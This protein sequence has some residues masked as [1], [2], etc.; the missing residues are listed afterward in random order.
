MKIT[1]PMMVFFLILSLPSYTYMSN[2]KEEVQEEQTFAQEDGLGAYIATKPYGM[3][4][5]YPVQQFY[6]APGWQYNSTPEKGNQVN[7]WV[8][9]SWGNGSYYRNEDGEYF[10]WDPVRRNWAKTR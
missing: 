9:P 7:T 10:F 2:K 4:N 6:K 3:D 5:Y 1:L 8:N